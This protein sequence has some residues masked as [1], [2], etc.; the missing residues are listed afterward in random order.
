MLPGQFGLL[1]LVL[2]SVTAE[3]GTGSIA[4][5]LQWTSRR[6]TL[7]LTRTVVTTATAVIAGVVLVTV[8]DVVTWGLAPVLEL[9]L[10]ELAASLARVA[11][12]VTGGALIAAGLGFLLRST[13]G[14]L[15]SIFLLMLVLP[16]VLPTFGIGWL[17]TVGTHLPG[18]AAL[19][20][21]SDDIDG[22][23]RTTATVVLAA[24]AAVATAAGAVSFLHRDAD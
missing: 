23:T 11:G 17:A 7:L 19:F 4:T 24:W 21:L 6:T 22:L 5:S 12:V 8:A 20:L 3:Y 18:G 1:V 15:A 9:S 2:L 14:A 13:A 16:L 10:P